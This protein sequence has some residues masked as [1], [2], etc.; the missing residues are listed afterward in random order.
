MLC[1]SAQLEG[2]HVD[3][4]VL[5]TAVSAHGAA[6]LPSIDDFQ[7]SSHGGKLAARCFEVQYV[8]SDRASLAEKWSK[9]LSHT[10]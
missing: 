5:N 3:V 2:G 7:A 6:K 4:A 10:F 8:R 1:D 9:T